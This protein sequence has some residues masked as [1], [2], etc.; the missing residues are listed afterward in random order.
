MPGYTERNNT[1]RLF[2]KK[3]SL[4]TN[5]FINRFENDEMEENLEYVEWIAE[6]RMLE[7]LKEKA[8]TLRGIR[9]EN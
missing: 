8:E 4:T 2:E 3:F 9:F 5:E 6:F 7:R 1:L